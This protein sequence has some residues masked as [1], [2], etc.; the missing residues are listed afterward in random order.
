MNIDHSHD[1][2]LI[3]AAKHPDEVIMIDRGPDVHERSIP[4]DWEL[5]CGLEVH[6]ELRRERLVDE[7]GGRV[8][9]DRVGEARAHAVRAV[10]HG[11]EVG[12][13]GAGAQPRKRIRFAVSHGPR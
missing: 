10:A 1:P 8:A 3:T 12:M 11:F 7:Q 2:E 13:E 5:V 9:L 4:D 6:V